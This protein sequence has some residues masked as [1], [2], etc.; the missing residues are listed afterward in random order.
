MSHSPMR[1]EMFGTAAVRLVFYLAPS[2]VFFL[3]DT[4][5]PT[6]AVSIKAQGQ[7]ALPTGHKRGKLRWKEAKIVAWSLFNI[8]LS[9]ALQ[10]AIEFTLTK[11]FRVRSAIKVAVRLPYPWGIVTDI[12]RGFVVREVSIDSLMLQILPSTIHKLTSADGGLPDSE[13]CSPPLC[14]AQPK[15][16]TGTITPVVVSF[17]AR[18]VAPDLS[19]RPPARLPGMEVPAIISSCGILPLPHD[20]LH[21][22]RGPRF[23]GGSV[24]VL[25]IPESANGYSPGRCC[26]KNRVTC[27]Q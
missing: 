22:L 3:F 10:G 16:S 9:I 26:A 7:V 21:G 15:L 4:L 11:T 17:P 6:A 19:L 20:N 1:V 13:L 12:V 2:I 23:A 18:P 8:I 24:R 25:W 5:L 14:L 27:D